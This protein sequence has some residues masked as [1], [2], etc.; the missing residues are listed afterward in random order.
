MGD[1]RWGLA[2]TAGAISWSHVDSNGFG[3]YIDV[4]AG[5]KWWIVARRKGGQHSFDVESFFNGDHEED[6]VNM[7]RWDL[8]AVILTPG[9]RL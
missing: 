7:D 3:T 5:S 1:I 2:A 6:Q 8:E 4:K 9:T